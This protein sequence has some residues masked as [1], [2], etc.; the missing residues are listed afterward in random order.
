MSSLL[1]L[2]TAGVAFAA[3]SAGPPV[4]SLSPPR[5]AGDVRIGVGLSPAL[6][7]PQ[8]AKPGD[9]VRYALRARNTLRST[10]YLSPVAVPLEGS[11]RPDATAQPASGN[12]RATAAAT[13]VTF[14]G[15]AAARPVKSGHQIDFTVEVHVPGTARPGTYAIGFAIRQRVSAGGNSI[16]PSTRVDLANM[17]T[18]RVVI[19]VPGD[20]VAQARVRSITGP[21]VVWGGGGQEFRARVVNVGDTDLLIDGKVDLNAFL[22]SAG[23]TLDAAGAEKGQPTLPDGQRDL[24]MRWGDPP[25]LGWFSPELTVV[26]GS[27]SGVRITRQLPTVYVLPPWWL[28]ALLV[29]ALLLPLWA[30]RRRRRR[31]GWQELDRARRAARVEE[32]LRKQG[33]MERARQARD[34]RRR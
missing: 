25:L 32:R 29:A 7:D 3:R 20:A 31:P 11:H 30:R 15:F 8:V 17:P 33:A 18:S 26:G 9:V 22:G 10:A 23:R 1:L 24:V 28:I 27:G 34:G 21:R 4:D 14:P 19:R 5:R 13:W 6:F 16:G 12:S 2:G